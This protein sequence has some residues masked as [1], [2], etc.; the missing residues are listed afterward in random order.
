MVV[1]VGDAKQLG[2]TVVSRYQDDHI[3]GKLVNFFGEQM[4]QPL[5]ERLCHCSYP[6]SLLNIQHRTVAGTND[7]PV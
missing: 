5:I 1:L 3:T 4:V 2:P 6:T 7:F